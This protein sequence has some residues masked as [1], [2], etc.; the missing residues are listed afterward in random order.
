MIL[1]S[2]TQPDAISGWQMDGVDTVTYTV[3]ANGKVFTATQELATIQNISRVK[4]PGLSV[5]N[6]SNINVEV[7]FTFTGLDGN[8]YSVTGSAYIL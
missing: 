7:E 1:I 3:T 4:F 8:A 5:N 6:G 2:A